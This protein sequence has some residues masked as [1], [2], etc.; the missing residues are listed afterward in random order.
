MASFTCCISCGASTLACK[1][2]SQAVAA[3]VWL[4]ATSLNRP[5]RD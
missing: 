2:A 5:A 3:S 1:V 4:L